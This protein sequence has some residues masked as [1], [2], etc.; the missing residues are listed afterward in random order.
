MAIKTAITT[1]P[2]KRIPFEKGIFE[3]NGRT[4]YIQPLE[5]HF[6]RLVLFNREKPVI[7]QGI[8]HEEAI[9]FIF[10]LFQMMSA[11][12]PKKG[13]VEVH[14]DALFML[15]QFCKDLE[16][17]DPSKVTEINYD[18]YMQFCTYFITVEGEDLAKYDKIEAQ[19]KIDDWKS[20]MYAED[21]FFAVWH[22]LKQSIAASDDFV[23]KVK[24]L[25]V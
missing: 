15:Q 9:R 1:K 19:K 23:Q 5:L 6:K 21:F 3:S 18:R 22:R 14:N 2:P 8:S 13:L 25:Q 10:K 24:N 17:K 4:Y 11:P 20:D 12:D 7:M 16:G